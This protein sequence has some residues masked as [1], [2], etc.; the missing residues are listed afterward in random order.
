[1]LSSHHSTTDLSDIHLLVKRRLAALHLGREGARQGAEE[2]SSLL[3]KLLF[4]RNIGGCP[5]AITEDLPAL[6]QAPSTPRHPGSPPPLPTLSS[7]P[8]HI[9]R[10]PPSLATSLTAKDPLALSPHLAED[11]IISQGGARPLPRASLFSFPYTSSFPSS[12]SSS[13]LTLHPVP[14]VFTSP[15]RLLK[16]SSVHVIEILSSDVEEGLNQLLDRCCDWQRKLRNLM[17]SVAQ[18][19]LVGFVC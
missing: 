6:A 19:G 3:S 11:M 16:Q 8:I 18:V 12:F 13:P 14:E 2:R 4:S 15:S 1:M 5:G 10:L 17:I 9:E 7:I